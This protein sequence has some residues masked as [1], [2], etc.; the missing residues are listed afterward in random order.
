LGIGGAG[1]DATSAF[2]ADGGATLAEA[3]F[4][5]AAFFAAGIFVVALAFAL[6][7]DCVGVVFFVVLFFAIGDS[8]PEFGA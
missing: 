7:A 1:T 5:V 6:L 8:F 3:A 4:F 2:G